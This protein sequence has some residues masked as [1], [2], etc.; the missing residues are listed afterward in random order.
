M[1]KVKSKV[2]CDTKELDKLIRKMKT[3]DGTIVEAGYYGEDEHPEHEVPMSNLALWQEE[4]T[5]NGIPERPFMY[6]ASIFQEKEL[7]AIHN[8]LIKD[9]LLDGNKIPSSLYKQLRP[10]EITMKASIKNVIYR[11]WFTEN[12]EYTVYLKGH[13]H[14]L[15]ET[16][17]LADSPKSNVLKNSS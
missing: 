2:K 8:R 9:Y 12:A 13:D 7:T 3:L 1:L 15:L 17:Y 4:G 11:G 14:P 5:K 6:Q 10:V 16:G